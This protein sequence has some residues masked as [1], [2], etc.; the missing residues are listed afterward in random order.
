MFKP[1]NVMTQEDRQRALRVMKRALLKANLVGGS[2]LALS[3]AILELEREAARY[4]EQ[5]EV[6]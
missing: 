5:T 2:A 6:T 1:R 4:C 3:R